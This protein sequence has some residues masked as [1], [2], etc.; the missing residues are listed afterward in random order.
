M[1]NRYR[2][3]IQGDAGAYDCIKHQSEKIKDKNKKVLP[4]CFELVI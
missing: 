1:I 2:G 3:G 4:V